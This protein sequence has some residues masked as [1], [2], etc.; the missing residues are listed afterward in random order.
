LGKKSYRKICVLILSASFLIL[1]RTERD[2]ITNVRRLV[3]LFRFERNLNC[4]DIFS[5]STRMSNFMKIRLVDQSCVKRTDGHDAA[6][7]CFLQFCERAKKCRNVR[8]KTHE[9]GVRNWC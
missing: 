7:S 3:F 9:L 6:D 8:I 2:F 5:K 4:L 1:R